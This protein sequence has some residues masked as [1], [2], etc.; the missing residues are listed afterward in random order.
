MT[1][2]GVNKA[3]ILNE[4]PL[5]EKTVNVFELQKQ[6]S[7]I[8]SSSG[9]SSSNNDNNFKGNKRDSDRL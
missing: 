6:H 9:V 8:S 2:N 5:N 1:A 4:E 3:F 7:S